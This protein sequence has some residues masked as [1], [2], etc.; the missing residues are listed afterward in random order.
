MDAKVRSFILKKNRWKENFFEFLIRASAFGVIA[1]L[2]LIFIFI[3]KEALP[4]FTSP[5]VRQ[6]A[7]LGKLFLP[8]VP[9]DL[10]YSQAHKF[11]WIPTSEIPK[12]SLIPLLAGTLK[13]TAV[14]LLLAVPLALGAALFTSEFAPPWLLQVMKPAIELLAGI[15]SVVMGF[16]ALMVLASWLEQMIHWTFRLN[17]ITAGIGVG[18]AVIPIIYTVTED[19]LS[20]VPTRFREG[21]DALGATRWQT[22][23][24]V[25]LPAAFP[26]VFAA[27]VLGFGRAIGETMIVLMA[28]GNAALVSLDFTQSVRTLSATIAAE[29]AEVV[30]GSSHY[31][32]LFF[33]GLFLFIFTFLTNLAGQWFVNRL[34]RKLTGG[35]K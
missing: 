13:I 27:C 5:E 6:E 22:A 4:I 34:R 29:L 19:A 25:I 28:S 3:G 14:A 2:L 8:N 12:Y 15:P 16:F 17:A 24:R 7:D 33:I 23:W 20:A 11:L 10:N 18:L 9:Q 32:V 21:S 30:R 26:G 31:H 1:T 35:S